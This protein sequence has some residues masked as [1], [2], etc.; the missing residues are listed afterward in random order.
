VSVGCAAAL[1]V[2]YLLEKPNAVAVPTKLILGAC[3]TIPLAPVLMIVSVLMWIEGWVYLRLS[4][5]GPG[6]QTSPELVARQ[7]H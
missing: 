1:A 3:V 5:H 7:Q 2:M 6:R 4:R